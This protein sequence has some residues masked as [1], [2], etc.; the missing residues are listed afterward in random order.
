MSIHP[1][2]EIKIRMDAFL[3]AVSRTVAAHSMISS[4]N[5]DNL[6]SR[7]L[8]ALSDGID[9]NYLEG[10][11]LKF[12]CD[13]ADLT[14]VKALI[15]KGGDIQ[16]AERRY[17]G[18]LN[19][20]IKRKNFELT[21]YLLSD[22]NINLTTETLFISIKYGTPE[23]LYLIVNEFRI[24]EINFLQEFFF[25]CPLDYL[26]ERLRDEECEE[27]KLRL[28]PFKHLF[29]TGK[30]F[31]ELPGFLRFSELPQYGWGL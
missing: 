12:W 20:A 26:L 13:R 14:I 6:N 4:E 24:R 15:E 3:Y 30:M 31:S 11:F 19:G 18:L 25:K 21:S 17:G 1:Q 29:S 23:N 9:V 22:V 28:L 5:K 7:F 16:K 10:S 27:T 8:L 2:T